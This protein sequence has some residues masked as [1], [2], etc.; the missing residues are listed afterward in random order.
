MTEQAG[1]IVGRDEELKR[2]TAF[3]SASAA[4]SPHSW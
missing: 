1:A 3:L 4:A 2:L